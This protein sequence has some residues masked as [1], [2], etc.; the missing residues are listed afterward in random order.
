MNVSIDYVSQVKARLT[1]EVEKED[2]STKL[3]KLL[4]NYRKNLEIPGFRK[5]N[6]PKSL[7]QK[8]Y[9][10]GAK[11]EVVNELV[12]EQ[13][14]KYLQDNKIDIL[15][16]PV[17][18]EDFVPYD[19]TTV[20]NFKFDF[21]LAIAPKINVSLD[22]NDTL[23]YYHIKPTQEMIEN[24][25]ESLRQ[26]FGEMGE[27][28]TI[29]E[30]DMVK[31]LLVELDGDRPKEGG[32]VK[33]NAS[34]IPKFLK[35]EDI[36]NEFIS[37]TKNTVVVFDPF[38]A[39]GDNN[40][41]IASFLGVD[42]DSV[43][44]YKG[45]SFSFEIQSVTRR[46]P[47]ELNEDLYKMAFGENTHVKTESDLRQEIESE[48]E[49]LF[50]ESSNN[51]LYNDVFNLISS[52]IGEPEFAKDVL[53]RFLLAKNNKAEKKEVEESMDGLLKDLSFDIAKRNIMR[54]NNARE[55]TKEDIE[56]VG[57][58]D[59][60]RQFA[61]YGMSQIP[62]DMLMD[63]LKK[64]LENKDAVAQYSQVAER[65]IFI[66]IVKNLVTLVEKTVNTDEFAEIVKQKD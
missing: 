5:G 49:K 34:F 33:E 16:E 26:S 3:E 2:Y 53:T 58:E 21:D 8:K 41:E 27:V 10:V 44:S 11:V 30:N 48:F 39:M 1:I 63:Y 31:G 59:V 43:S 20:E 15:G 19:F 51:K 56:S 62:D 66:D 37:K 32:L 4:N 25:V 42:K 57:K 40:V 28:E 17:Q 50:V 9:G 35:D 61:Q 64:T 7:V 13:L 55:I 60:R 29:E 6:A 23:D 18:S 47:A 36:K 46:F 24:Q 45:Q 65:R 22:K 38:K 52:K 14:V 12:S 54:D